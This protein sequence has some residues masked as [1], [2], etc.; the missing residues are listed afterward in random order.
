MSFIVKAFE[1]RTHNLLRTITYINC[2]FS[3]FEQSYNNRNQMWLTLQ[4]IKCFDGWWCKLLY[5][6]FCKYNHYIL[7]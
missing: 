7:Y 4:E 1:C 5:W 3:Q 2:I 6:N